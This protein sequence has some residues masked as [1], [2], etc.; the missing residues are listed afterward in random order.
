M[1]VPYGAEIKHCPSRKRNHTSLPDCGHSHKMLLTTTRWRLFPALRA[2]NAL[3]VEGRT[4]EYMLPSARP[5][6][7]LIC[8]RGGNLCTR[9]KLLDQRHQPSP[10][11][12]SL[13]C[14]FDLAVIEP[15]ALLALGDVRGLREDWYRIWR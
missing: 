5:S 9:R 10:D 1:L 6:I 4:P 12:R 2:I 7:S 3:P 13:D 15:D 14:P 8:A 11:E